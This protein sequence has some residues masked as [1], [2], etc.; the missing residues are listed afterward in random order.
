ML[1]LV[2]GTAIV[3]AVVLVVASASMNFTFAS[4][5]G[6]TPAEGF[7]LGA[8]AVGVDVLKAVL[9]ILIGTAA[10][11]RRW[12]FVLIGSGAFVL[13]ASLS[14]AA[15]FGF[16][17]SNRQAVLGDR[18]RSTHRVAALERHVAELRTKL[19]AL[20]PHRVL[21]LVDEAL[22]TAR[23]DPQWIASRQ[24]S[25]ITT[26]RVRTLCEGIAKLRSER[27]AGEAALRFEQQIATHDSEIETLRQAGSGNDADPQARSMAHALGLSEAQVQRS[28][29]AL[30]AL[31][32]EVGSAL[33]VYIALGH[34]LLAA[35]SPRDSKQT[36]D[37]VGVPRI[38]EIPL[39]PE[40]ATTA[41]ASNALV[42]PNSTSHRPGVAVSARLAPRRNSGSL[43]RSSNNDAS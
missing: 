29:S 23:T 42:P 3:A 37:V 11:A 19:Q 20:P 28:L 1:K 21:A 35:E 43:L 2:T 24:C 13:F 17:A 38:Q 22:T 6:R 15:A 4:S 18:D 31:V 32:V 36:D 30:L 41:V 25:S 26:T 14:L 34:R 5:L 33:G 39:Q 40:P 27:I 16:S 12:I 7:I 8:I 10:R 9:A